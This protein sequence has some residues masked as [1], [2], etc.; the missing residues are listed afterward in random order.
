[1]SSKVCL[2]TATG[3]CKAGTG[4]VNDTCS[5]C[6][7]GTYNS[8]SSLTCQSCANATTGTDG[9]SERLISTPVSLQGAVGDDECVSQY[10][11]LSAYTET[12]LITDPSNMVDL[13]SMDS[14]AACAA[15]CNS[16]CQF[17]SFGYSST[18]PISTMGTCYVHYARGRVTA[19]GSSSQHVYFKVV[20]SSQVLGA[21]VV[22]RS[23]TNTSGG[24]GG[25]Y[26]KW[27]VAAGEVP[28]G[29]SIRTSFDT[30]LLRCLEECDY[31]GDCVLAYYTATAESSN[32]TLKSGLPALGYRTA[33]QAL[34][35]PYQLVQGAKKIIGVA[36]SRDVEC[37]SGIC[38]VATQVCSSGKQA[39]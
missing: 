6:P 27:S 8:G 23:A 28:L 5:P 29:D 30:S 21:S 34:S 22:A 7:S 12:T 35:S 19:G 2:H 33:V 38:N 20:R 14:I 32:C 13:G 39:I 11:E 17:F 10:S 1:M 37:E 4:L 26:M 31:E 24:G 18:D 3:A 9:K 36:C 25:W 15:A 16:T